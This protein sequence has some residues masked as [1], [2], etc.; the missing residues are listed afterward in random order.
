MK[1]S[2][3]F[4]LALSLYLF[5]CTKEEGEDLPANFEGYTYLPLQANTEFQFRI[6]SI[7]YDD[8]TG[9]VDTFS[10]FRKE[11]IK[12]PVEDLGGRNTFP[13]EI[14]QRLND[15]SRWTLIAHE[16][17]YR[18]TYRYELERNS[19]AYVPLVFPP[20]EESRWNVNALNTDEEKVY[21]YD[22]L[23]Q[24]FQLEGRNFDST[25]TVL[26]ENQLSL[27]NVLRAREVYGSGWGLIYR[28]NEDYSTDISS[29][30]IIS[31]YKRYQY[32]ISP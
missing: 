9:T 6:D 25:I 8:F 7:A 10:Y 13:V 18:G 16:Y 3:L 15:S 12:A 32:L 22:D 2:V 29:G 17:R 14:Y 1:Q 26:Q 21:R 24:S 28:E 23:H 27:I 5:S 19:I 4:L 11:E 20:L 30:E 31:G